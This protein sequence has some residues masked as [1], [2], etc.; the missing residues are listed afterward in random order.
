M[1]I[2]RDSEVG[3]KFAAM[4]E[5]ICEVLGSIAAEVLIV[6]QLLAEKTLVSDREYEDAHGTFEQ[7]FGKSYRADILKQI[8]EKCDSAVQKMREGPVN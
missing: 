6:R 2:P 3:L 5:A 1:E 4:S 8:Y 7:R